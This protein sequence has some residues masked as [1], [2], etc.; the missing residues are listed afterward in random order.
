MSVRQPSNTM[1]RF[2]LVIISGVVISATALCLFSTNN[3]TFAVDGAASQALE[4]APPV[5]NLS[6]N[7][8]ETVEANISIRNVSTVKQLVSGELNDF[9]ANGDDGT[10]KIILD[11]SETSPYSFKQWASDIDDLTLDAK[12]LATLKLKITIPESAAPGGYYGIVRF[13]STPPELKDTGVSLSASLGSLILLK[14]NGDA[15]ES[16]SIDGFFASS[17][18]K[19]GTLFEAAPVDF[20]VLLKNDGNVHEQPVGQIGITDMF[21]KKI[22][23]V[24]V[25]IPIRNILPASTR[26][27]DESLNKEV[28]GNKIL[29]G[30]YTANL[31]VTYGKD[32]TELVKTIEFWVIPYKMI[33]AFII[34][35]IIAFL[36]LKTLIQRY[37]AHIIKSSQQSHHKTKR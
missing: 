8:G 25:N 35:L 20:T 36:V 2:K 31:K 14:V 30:K 6:A 23:N 13:T 24:N 17:D 3:F 5:I 7:P 26:K 18:G 12:K 27:F 9:V 19:K 33:A 10:P 22:A 1:N 4:I 32:K 34:I 21:G 37:N 29:F 16:L 28:L 11:E 15:L